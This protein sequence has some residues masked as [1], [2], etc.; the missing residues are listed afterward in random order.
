[1]I[2]LSVVCGNA[3]FFAEILPLS[4]T[5]DF[6]P[7]SKQREDGGGPVDVHDRPEPGFGYAEVSRST[8]LFLKKKA[9]ARLLSAQ[10]W[11][12]AALVK[13]LLSFL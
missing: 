3:S 5:Q 13:Q 4:V 11:A 1:M 9:N 7:S 10:C 12:E 2:F 6:H 8:A